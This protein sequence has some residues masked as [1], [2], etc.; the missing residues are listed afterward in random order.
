MTAETPTAEKKTCPTCGAPIEWTRVKDIMMYFESTT[1]T[2]TIE[3][4][5]CSDARCGWLYVW[6]S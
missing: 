6:E 4:E 1:H 2:V 3:A 5:A